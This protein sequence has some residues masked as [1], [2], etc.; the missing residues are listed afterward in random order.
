MMGSVNLDWLYGARRSG[1]RLRSLVLDVETLPDLAAEVRRYIDRAFDSAPYPVLSGPV[2]PEDVSAVTFAVR[3]RQVSE[4]ELA[5]LDEVDRNQLQLCVNRTLYAAALDGRGA[6][7]VGINF[8]LDSESATIDVDVY[9]FGG[10]QEGHRANVL[11]LATHHLYLRGVARPRWA[12]VAALFWFLPLGL[13]SASW[14]WLWAELPLAA[15]LLLTGVAVSVFLVCLER[16]RGVLARMPQHGSF[17]YRGESRKQTYAR[18]ADRKRDLWVALYAVVGTLL[19]GFLVWATGAIAG[20][21]AAPEP[22][23]SSHSGQESG[24]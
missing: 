24:G 3:D 16:F 13:V 18:R 19:V 20:A 17:V 8:S 2:P 14:L 21:P 23:P 7:L 11:Q 22:T 5:E 9:G 12:S 15:H 4:A 6:P 1:G 10:Y